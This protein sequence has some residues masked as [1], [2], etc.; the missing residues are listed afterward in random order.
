MF[1]SLLQDLVNRDPLLFAFALVWLYLLFTNPRGAKEN[2]RKIVSLF[3]DIEPQDVPYPQEVV[4]FFNRNF[5]NIL[6]GYE[7]WLGN[8]ANTISQKLGSGN[9]EKQLTALLFLFIF[10]IGDAIA[11]ANL[12]ELAGYP[13]FINILPAGAI[14]TFLS[15]Y[16]NAITIGTFFSAIVTGRIVFEKLHQN[17]TDNS[18]HEHETKD[19]SNLRKVYYR[20]A[21]IT[22]ISSILTSSVFGLIA[23]TVEIGELPIFFSTVQLFF[24]HILVRFNLLITSALL[25]EQGLAGLSLVLQ[26]IIFLITLVVSLVAPISFIILIFFTK[27]TFDIFIRMTLISFYTVIL[28]ILSP[29]ERVARVPS[30]LVR[31][32]KSLFEKPSDTN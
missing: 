23:F 13:S 3:K 2:I 20:L 1:T 12:S 24:I 10:F 6:K 17:K 25:F 27:I 4:D 28:L 14:R 9:A 29:L 18:S 8:I 7:R 15:D 30:E 32:I 11:I 5:G 21:W 16:G 26:M 31:S 19:I 22:F